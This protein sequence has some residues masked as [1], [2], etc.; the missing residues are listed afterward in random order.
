MAK[1]LQILVVEETGPE[2]LS[3]ELFMLRNPKSFDTSFV[4]P[5]MLSM[6]Y[7][8]SMLGFSKP[9]IDMAPEVNRLFA[10]FATAVSEDSKDF[11][12]SGDIVLMFDWIRRG[13]VGNK[14]LLGEPGDG[15]SAGLSSNELVLLGEGI[16]PGLIGD[17]PV[18]NRDA[19]LLVRDG[20][21]IKG[22]G[23]T[24]EAEGNA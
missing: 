7:P 2:I 3:R 22:P 20:P 23:V 18:C 24:G 9:E 5:S 14:D 10:A 12:L 4:V 15:L 1:G 11:G 17:A 13:R 19:G 6:M 21:G 16:D 8:R